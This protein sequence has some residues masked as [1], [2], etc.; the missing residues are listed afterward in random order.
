MERNLLKEVHEININQNL[1]IK[2]VA[3]RPSLQNVGQVAGKDKTVT[4]ERCSDSLKSVYY[5]TESTI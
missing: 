4:A 3:V 2:W 1:V 5:F